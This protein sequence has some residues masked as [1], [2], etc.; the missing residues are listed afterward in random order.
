METKTRAFNCA[1]CQMPVS[2]PV[3]RDRGHM[4]CSPICSKLGR[5]KSLRAAGKRYQSTRIGK[6]KNAKRQ[7]DHRV[8]KKE[9]LKK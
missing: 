6:F 7:H 3:N 9:L 5:K 8:R 2:I 4:Y 1:W